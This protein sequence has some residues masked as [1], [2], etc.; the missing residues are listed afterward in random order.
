MILSIRTSLFWSLLIILSNCALSFGQI[1]TSACG[2]RTVYFVASLCGHTPPS[3]LG[4]AQAI[5]LSADGSST[6]LGL[7]TGLAR[8]GINSEG[9]KLAL[10]DLMKTELAI[11]TIDTDDGPHFVIFF[12]N[13]TDGQSISLI[14][15]PNIIKIGIDTLRNKW[16]GIALV[17]S[18]D[19]VA[20]IAAASNHRSNAVVA[21]TP[22]PVSEPGQSVPTDESW[23][24]VSPVQV[25]DDVILP[26]RK[27]IEI[28][29]NVHNLTSKPIEI[30][31]IATSCGCTTAKA[32][33]NTILPGKNGQIAI[34]INPIGVSPG[35]QTYNAIIIP[36]DDKIKPLS[37]SAR[38][39]FHAIVQVRPQR[40]YF[41]NVVRGCK[42]VAASFD[43]V[44][45]QELVNDV[46]VVSLKSSVPWLQPES[47]RNGHIVVDL[48]SDLPIGPFQE[49]ISIVTSAGAVNVPV[50]GEVVGRFRAVPNPLLV[51]GKQ[52]DCQVEI[53]RSP[54]VDTDLSHLIL[55]YDSDR[56]QADF[57][58]IESSD[59]VI[60]RIHF[61]DAAK[62][63]SIHT[64][65]VS[66]TLNHE[67]LNVRVV[68]GL[69]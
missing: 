41:G 47:A 28:T 42:G 9:R 43:I 1:D 5:N 55:N 45:D 52:A 64:V 19:N 15:P 61:K 53:V 22:Q 25:F 57:I 56:L 38:I 44:T 65:S 58:K 11:I 35:W 37:L 36:V 67:T 46:S 54:G 13:S 16:D 14:D 68:R 32:D 51:E 3:L 69:D 34:A 60:L 66:D 8:Y 31:K 40:L 23:T 29:Y 33:K 59:H 6:L 24:A 20:G 18:N 7:K 12:R 21:I 63:V 50:I 26:L 39:R 30:K 4:V 10:T 27:P 17:V 49:I 62:G 48:N 2:V